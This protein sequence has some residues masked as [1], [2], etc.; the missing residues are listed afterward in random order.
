MYT[1]LHTHKPCMGGAI[2]LVLDVAEG[3]HTA[4][5]LNSMAAGC[6]N[7][8]SSVC[9]V[10]RTNEC[11]PCLALGDC[12]ALLISWAVQVVIQSNPRKVVLASAQHVVQ[13]MYCNTP[14]LLLQCCKGNQGQK[15]MH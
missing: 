15:Q 10:L 1:T 9:A 4:V 14:M 5:L 6:E 7:I 12:P 3:R 2:W 13:Q 8:Q 11:Q